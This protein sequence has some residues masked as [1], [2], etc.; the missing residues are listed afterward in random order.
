MASMN[1]GAIYVSYIQSLLWL[2]LFMAL[3]SAEANVVQLLFIDFVHGNPHRTQ[4]NA[5]FMMKADTP[6]FGIIAFIGTLLVF[7]LPQFF[8]AEVIRALEQIFGDRARFAALLALPLTTLLTWYCCDYLMPSNLCF[9]GNCMEPYEHGLSLSRYVG[10]CTIQAPIT[11]FSFLYLDA[12]LRGVSRMP[13][14]LGA[15]A[16][17]VVAGGFRG[18][19]EALG[20]YRFL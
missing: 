8:Q 18:Y 16:I 1:R 9:A 12:N 5:I 15:L 6:L 17:A 2:A 4:E 3:I 20:Q 7:T 14:L 11:L 10:T 13:V 19:V